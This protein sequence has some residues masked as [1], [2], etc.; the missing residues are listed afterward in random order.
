VDDE[1]L[2]QLT[3]GSG[4]ATTRVLL[5]SDRMQFLA[6]DTVDRFAGVFGFALTPKGDAIA[7]GVLYCRSDSSFDEVTSGGGSYGGFDVPW[8]PRD[9]GWGTSPVLNMG[10]S[11]TNL[12]TSEGEDT[13]VLVHTGFVRPGVTGIE[14]DDER[15][16]R[17]VEVISPCGAF[18]T[19]TLGSSTVT[20]R[21]LTHDD[22]V[23]GVTTY[24]P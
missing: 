2:L 9:G 13:L 8:S 19:L 4:L 15:G 12:E 5:P 6:I 24:E 14:I 3:R 16:V 23:V 22:E 7:G 1:E 18:A 20:F 17:R 10:T 11:G 21:Y